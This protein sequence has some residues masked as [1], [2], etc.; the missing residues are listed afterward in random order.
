MGERRM[1][2]E[3]NVAAQEGGHEASNPCVRDQLLPRPGPAV[4]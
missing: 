1:Q 3:G 2:K 4:C